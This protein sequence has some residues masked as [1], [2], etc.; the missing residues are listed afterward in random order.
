MEKLVMVTFLYFFRLIN[1]NNVGLEI[2]LIYIYI[3][4]LKH[5]VL[6]LCS[7]SISKIHLAYML[8]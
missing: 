3:S 2:I 5:M 1:Y 6:T 8:L 4:F 7:N